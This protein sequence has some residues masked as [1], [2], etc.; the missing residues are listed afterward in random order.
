MTHI[1]TSVLTLAGS[2]LI[3]F[4]G[5]LEVLF[6]IYTICL[7]LYYKNEHDSGRLLW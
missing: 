3:T 4:G 5:V 1:F 7:G 2:A 6:G